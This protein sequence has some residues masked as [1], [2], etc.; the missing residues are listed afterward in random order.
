MGAYV[1]R[2][3][4]DHINRWVSASGMIQDL[5]CVIM[6]SAGACLLSM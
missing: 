2:I 3:H 6:R 5:I 4:A 1:G